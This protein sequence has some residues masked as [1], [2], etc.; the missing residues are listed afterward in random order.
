MNHEDVAWKSVWNLFGENLSL[1]RFSMRKIADG[2]R[3]ISIES[4]DG[5][6]K[7]NDNAIFDAE[8]AGVFSQQWIDEFTPM[9]PVSSPCFKG[10][11]QDH[12][13]SIEKIENFKNISNRPDK[14]F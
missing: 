7:P 3:Q 11:P 9:H 6:I 14:W 4:T 13:M 1:Q 2:T 8:T 10:W 12:S 5:L